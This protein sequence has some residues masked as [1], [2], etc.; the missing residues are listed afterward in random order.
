MV[1]CREKVTWELGK[2]EDVQVLD[3]MEVGSRGTERGDRSQKDNVDVEMDEYGLWRVWRINSSA[4]A[5]IKRV[6][7][8]TAR[9][10]IPS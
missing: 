9:H 7:L 6:R 8:H 2:C 1:C 5:G 3:V 10:I 4:I